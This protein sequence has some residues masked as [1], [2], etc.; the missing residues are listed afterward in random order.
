MV[1]IVVLLLNNAL[2]VNPWL[3]VFILALGA[4]MAVSFGMI[5]ELY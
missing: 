5:L 1:G 4:L 3:L 2:G